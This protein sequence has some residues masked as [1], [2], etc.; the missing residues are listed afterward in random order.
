MKGVVRKLPAALQGKEWAIPIVLGAITLLIYGIEIRY[1]DRAYKAAGWPGIAPP[2]EHTAA[3]A[4]AVLACMILGLLFATIT[5]SGV[6]GFIVGRRYVEWRFWWVLATQLAT[7]VV[8]ATGLKYPP[9]QLQFAVLILADISLV[10]GYSLGRL[11]E[12]SRAPALRAVTV[13]LAVLSLAIVWT[14]TIALVNRTAI[15][16]VRSIREGSGQHVIAEIVAPLEFR[17]VRVAWLDPAVRP[18]IDLDLSRPL[19]LV[20]R[21]EGRLL[22]VE[23]AAEPGEP[24]RR[25]EIADDR[26]ELIGP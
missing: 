8:V 26:V 23:V 10:V 16:D 18:G 1:Y 20:G 9:Q 3:I 7:T 15:D 13:T 21:H 19:L 25:F 24:L 2:I 17:V 22:L 11:R 6:L 4:R 5:G 14:A 12:P